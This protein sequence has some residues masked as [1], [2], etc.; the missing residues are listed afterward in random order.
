MR[1]HSVPMTVATQ[2]ARVSVRT[3]AAKPEMARLPVTH[4]DQ[5]EARGP[6]RHGQWATVNISGGVMKLANPAGFV[7]TVPP[8]RGRSGLRWRSS[9]VSVN[10]MPSALS[11]KYTTH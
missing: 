1:M 8:G 9:P 3:M 5:V 10:V 6:D 11:T 2:A 7:L 4:G